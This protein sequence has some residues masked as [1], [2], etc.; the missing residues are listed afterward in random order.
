MYEYSSLMG[1]KYIYIY[2]YS[3]IYLSHICNDAIV[4]TSFSSVHVAPS[5]KCSIT[6]L[7]L[8][9]KNLRSKLLIVRF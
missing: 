4:Y 2:I 1:V 3:F 8:M 7:D 6:I 5:C 9:V